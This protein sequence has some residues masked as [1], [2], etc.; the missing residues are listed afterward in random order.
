[1]YR[2]HQ[3]VIF[4]NHHKS[5]AGSGSE[6]QQRCPPSATSCLFSPLCWPRHLWWAALGNWAGVELTWQR[7]VIMIARGR[8]RRPEQGPGCW[9]EAELWLLA[10]LP[11]S[12]ALCEGTAL[13]LWN[14]R[15][16]RLLWAFQYRRKLRR[17]RFL[18]PMVKWGWFIGCLKRYSGVERVLHSV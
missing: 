12:S 3:V 10:A 4:P 7:N 13:A 2:V 14:L 17:L 15:D 18:Q 1:M 8:R 16:F 6:E 5:S 9:R 11:A